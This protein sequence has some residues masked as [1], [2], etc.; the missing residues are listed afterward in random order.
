ELAGGGPLARPVRAA[1]DDDAAGPADAF[2]AIVVEGDRLLAPGHEAFVHHVEHLEE[3]HVRADV[4]GAIGDERA[5][6]SSVL[7]AP[8]LQGEMHLLVAP[9]R[10]VDVLEDERLLVAP[11]R[12][13]RARV[14][15]DGDVAEAGIIALR[16]AV[17]GL[18][19]LPEVGS[20]GFLAREGV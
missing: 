3:R 12:L 5:R 13:A 2:A 19:L 6:R 4:V 16:L 20:T 9:R 8:D 14:L 17:R 15:P 10:Q 11:R 7:L 18:V 1:V